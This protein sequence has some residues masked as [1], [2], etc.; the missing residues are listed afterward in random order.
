MQPQIDDGSQLLP[1]IRLALPE[2]RGPN[3]P[4][5]ST[6]KFSNCWVRLGVPS[7]LRPLLH[8]GPERIESQLCGRQ[9]PFVR[10]PR[11]PAPD[12]SATYAASN[13]P[14]RSGRS[15]MR[16]GARRWP[17]RSEP[18]QVRR[19]S[20]RLRRGAWLETARAHHFGSLACKPSADRPNGRRTGPFSLR[21]PP[22][23][24][25]HDEPPGAAPRR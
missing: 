10:R 17:R 18:I 6:R 20:G 7:A 8:S 23:G 16:Q 22:P 2:S 21:A 11:A 13:S 9:Q 19:H 24:T 5:A 25:D 14:P 3:W 1:V 12:Q 15:H 4:Y